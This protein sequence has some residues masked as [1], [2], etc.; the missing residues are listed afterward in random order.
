MLRRLL[1]PGHL[2]RK[3]RIMQP[4]HFDFSWAA[5]KDNPYPYYAALRETAAVCSFP[6]LGGALAVSRYDDVL[7]VLKNPALF[8]SAKKKELMAQMSLSSGG[9]LARMRSAQMLT[10][11]DPP[12]HTRLRSLVSRAFTP[13]RIAAM[14]PRI[15]AITREL[16]DAVLPKGEMELIEDLAAPLPIRVIAEMLGVEPERQHDFKRWSDLFVSAFTRAQ[17]GGDMTEVETGLRELRLYLEGVIAERRQE[18]RDDLISALLHSGEQEGV[19]SPDDVVHFAN[20]LLVAGNETTTNLIGNGVRALLDNPGERQKLLETPKLIPNAIEEM[21]RYDPPVQAMFRSAV[22]DVI[23]GGELI[24]AGAPVVAFLGAANRDPR[25]YPDPD[26]FDVT[27]DAA[28]HVAFGHGIH[29]CL[30]APLA[31]LEAKV[32]LE[33]LLARMP[34]LSY[35]SGQPEPITWVDAIMFRGPKSLRLRVSPASG[36]RSAPPPAPG[37]RPR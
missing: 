21:L 29:F 27:R 15:R 20:L 10:A 28:G 9:E 25:R 37:G 17:A 3:E 26:R 19:L 7:F 2:A 5:V 34:G 16:L 14:E 33:E 13:H 18:P 23:V 36:A 11:S 24:P 8:S 6:A 12:A 22:E 32:A 35:P 31:R 1:E 4:R 30:G